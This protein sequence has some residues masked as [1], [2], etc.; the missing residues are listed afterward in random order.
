MAVIKG[1]DS[2]LGS[3]FGLS[4]ADLIEMYR[5]VALARAV[6]ERMWI[7]NRA[8]RIPFVI[9][10]Q[11]HEGAQ[12]GIAWAFQRGHDWIAPFYRS[13]A[14]CLTFGMSPRDIMTA[15]YATASDPSSGGRQMPGHYGSREHNLVSVSSPVATQ[16]LHAVGIALAAKI[17]KTGQVAMASMGEGSSNQGDVHEGLNFAAIHKLPF[18]FVVENN[19]YAISVPAAMQ[20]SV[21]DVAERAA[22]YGIPGIVVD[23]ADVLACYAASRNAVAR[24]RAGD[25][26]TLI[27]AKV[28]RLTAHSSD[29]QQTK[30]RTPED[31]AEG[32]EHDAL[33]RFRTQLRDAG[34]LTDAIEARLIAEIAAAVEDATEFAESEPD[35]DPAMAMRYVYDEVVD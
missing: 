24:A 15:Q 33:P 30:Y 26:P 18:I 19:G 27:E 21:A 7:L 29:D 22:G 4:N 9:S 12:V 3:A 28:A 35:P 10:G 8:G 11:G 20:V 1:S 14:T 13:I 31:L 16:L 6:D 2:Q 25:G 17:R 23:G 34:V 32:S 5:Y